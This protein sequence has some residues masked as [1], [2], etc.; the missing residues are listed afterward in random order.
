PVRFANR[1]EL[2]ADAPVWGPE[3]FTE[4]AAPHRA[5]T[6][7]WVEARR[8][9]GDFVWVPADL[10]L[11]GARPLTSPASAFAIESSNG[12]AAHTA[13]PSAI[14]KAVLELVERH[15]VSL[16]ELR[17]SHAPMWRLRALCK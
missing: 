12:M 10:V 16:C 2:E 11:T 5:G 6:L 9:S 8:S 4:K 7:G 13:F 15:V 1:L 3:R 14:E 17:A